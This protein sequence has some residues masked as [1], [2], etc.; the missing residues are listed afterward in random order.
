MVCQ[1]FSQHNADHSE[2]SFRSDWNIQ[3]LKDRKRTE[4]E[5]GYAQNIFHWRPL[6]RTTVRV[7]EQ[8][9]MRT[10]CYHVWC[11]KRERVNMMTSSNGNIRPRYWPFVWGIHRSPVNSPHKGQWRGALMFCLICAWI[12]GWVNNGEADDLRRHPTHYDV[13]VML[14][15]WTNNCPF[16][17][18]NCLF[19]RK[20]IRLQIDIFFPWAT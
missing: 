14:F 9:F 2:G 16:P 17:T 15:V 4:P 10:N 8:L 6:E 13:I 11:P 1:P 5:R 20:I 7:N 18:N 12:K 3:H 19:A